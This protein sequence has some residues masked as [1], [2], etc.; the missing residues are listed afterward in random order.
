MAHKIEDVIED[1]ALA[2]DTTAMLAFAVMDAGKRIAREIDRLGLNNAVADGP[3]GPLEMMC[4]QQ[5]DM[6]T[7]MDSI[8]GC[9]EQLVATKTKT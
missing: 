2:G 5:R 6:Q 7:T 3:P 8:A 4:I 1:A 9:F